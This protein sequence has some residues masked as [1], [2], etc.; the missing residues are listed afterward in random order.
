[1]KTTKLSQNSIRNEKGFG[2][3]ELTVVFSILG[4]IA[5]VALPAYV[6]YKLQQHKAAAQ[7]EVF[8]LHNS[9]EVVSS[10]GVAGGIEG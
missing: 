8:N 3:A 1:M 7:S 6:S 9:S 2:I 10:H 5:S 4:V